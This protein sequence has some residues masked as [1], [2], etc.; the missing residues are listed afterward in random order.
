M[1]NEE[2]KIDKDCGVNDRDEKCALNFVC[3][4]WKEETTWMT[5]A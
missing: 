5:S 2:E 4:T 1:I 3:K